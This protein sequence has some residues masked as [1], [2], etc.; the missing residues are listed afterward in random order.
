M[1]L[2]V[3]GTAYLLGAVPWGLLLARRAG[4]DV[5]RAGSGN[6]GATNVLRTAGVGL[7]AMTLAADVL[8]GTI[9]VA[10]AGWVSPDP[11]TA[12]LSGLL[13]FLGH[14]FPVTLRFAGGKGVATACGVVL[15]LCPAAAAGAVGVFV[16]AVALCRYVSVASILAALAA[17]VAT[18]WLRCPGVTTLATATM[19]TVIVLRHRENLRRLRAGTEP[20][21][22]LHKRQA[23]PPK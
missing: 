19:A 12:A 22:T 9:A 7:G 18:A 11:A 3:L 17:P 15:A 21:L 4:I 13:V 16:V 2:L 5:R 6:I 10:L 23:A 8:K 14:V 1:T 20:P